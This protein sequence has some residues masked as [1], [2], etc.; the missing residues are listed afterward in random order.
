MLQ[1]VAFHGIICCVA[2][3]YIRKSSRQLTVG[4]RQKM[5]LHKCATQQAIIVVIQPGP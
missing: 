3:L 5:K 1:T 2:H 4:C